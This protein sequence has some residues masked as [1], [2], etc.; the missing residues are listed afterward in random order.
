MYLTPFGRDH[1]WDV[2]GLSMVIIL[3]PH[4]SLYIV[5]VH[6][7]NLLLSNQQETSIVYMYIHYTIIPIM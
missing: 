6:H 3:M 4:V 5:F 1:L 7:K 2:H